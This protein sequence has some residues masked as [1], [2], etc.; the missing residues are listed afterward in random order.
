VLCNNEIAVPA[1]R[2]LAFYGGLRAVIVPEKNKELVTGL[3]SLFT[4]SEV[5]VIAVSKNNFAASITSIITSKKIVS[6]W[7]MTFPWLIPSSLLSVPSRGFINFHYGLLPQYR[8]NNPVL[9][10][11]LR[12]EKQGGITVHIA[13]ENI[14]SGPIVMQQTIPIEDKDTFS[15]QLQK[16]SMLGAAM[17]TN[18]LRIFS[19][20]TITPSVPQDE[21]KAEYFKKPGASDLMIDWNNMNSWQIIRMINACNPWN[22]GAATGYNNQIILFTE[23]EITHLVAQEEAPG[24]ITTLNATEGL[25]VASSD[26]KVIRVNVV[27]TEHGIFSGK[28]LMEYGIKTG[29]RF[30]TLKK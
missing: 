25:Q 6:V 14:D 12:F 9:T 19:Y 16:L 7:I 27:C 26:K 29:D 1:L 28:K 15:I 18:L 23:A 2:E 4:N 24:M 22:K 11:M 13:D 20:S 5:E 3:R 30:I 8:G 10:Q 17:A 21:S